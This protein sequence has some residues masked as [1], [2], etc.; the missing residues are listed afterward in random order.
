M[1]KLLSTLILSKSVSDTILIFLKYV[2]NFLF[3]SNKPSFSI[4][5]KSRISK[6]LFIEVLDLGSSGE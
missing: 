2:S 4:G 5:F 6:T 1:N 3:Y